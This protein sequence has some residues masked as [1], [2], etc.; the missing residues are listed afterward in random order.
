MAKASKVYKA[1][2]GLSIRELRV[3]R[4]IGD[5][6]GLSS[7][8]LAE[9]SL[10]EQTLVSKHLRKLVAEGYVRRELESVEIADVVPRIDVAQSLET[11]HQ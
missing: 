11:L 3:L 6:P 10:I 5:E 1:E 9:A 7:G 4:T 2:L 8:A